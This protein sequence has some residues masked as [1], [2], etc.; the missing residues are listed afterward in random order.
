MSTYKVTWISQVYGESMVEADTLEEAS[1][2]ARAG[3][4]TDWKELEPS[5]DWIIND[6][7]KIN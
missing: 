4:D 7:E 6:I 1:S 5:E 3:K 2:K